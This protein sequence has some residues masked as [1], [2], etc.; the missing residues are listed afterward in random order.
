ME[1]MVMNKKKLEKETTALIASM[2]D[3]LDDAETQLDQCNYDPEN[4]PELA[5][6]LKNVRAALKEYQK[7]RTAHYVNGK[8][9]ATLA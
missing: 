8:F 4:D 5:E 7:F 1:S 2:A 3:A 6:A 9:S